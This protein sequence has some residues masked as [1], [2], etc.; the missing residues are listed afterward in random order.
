VDIWCANEHNFATRQ[1]CRTGSKEHN[2]WIA[3]RAKDLGG[4]WQPYKGLT[5]RSGFVSA[6]TEA[7]IYEALNLPFIPPEQRESGQFES[8]ARIERAP[9]HERKII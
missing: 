6:T 5:L 7:Q 4:D 1:L 3:E 9:S 8:F 2:I